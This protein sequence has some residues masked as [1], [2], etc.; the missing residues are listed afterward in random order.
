MR[1]VLLGLALCACAASAQSLS[2]GVLGGVPFPDAVNTV[3]SSTY[4]TVYKSANFIVGPALQINLPASFRIEA[5]AL[6][7]PVNFNVTTPVTAFT[8]SAAQWKFPFLLQYRF[9]TPVVKPFVEAGAS[10]D[11]LSNISAAAKAV[12][13]G[14]GQVLQQS[15]GSAV[16]GAGVDVKVPFVRLSGELRYEH[17][18]SADFQ[19]LSNLNQAEVLIGVHF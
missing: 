17:A 11:R 19:G 9:K 18:G 12:T 13:S 2:V 4:S 16:L 8:S 15:H 7:R 5:D 10:F 3:Q 1:N 6:Y 14:T